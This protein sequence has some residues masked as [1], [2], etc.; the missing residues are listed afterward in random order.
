MRFATLA[1][2][3]DVGALARR[4]YRPT[5]A[6]GL[7]EAERVLLRANPQL[8]DPARRAP[9]V[10][11][12]VPDVTGAS[13]TN[14]AQSERQLLAS[15]LEA[16]RAQLGE[17]GKALGAGLASRRADVKA[18]LDQLGSAEI[19]RLLRE[20]PQLKDVL[21]GVSREAR[22]ETAE[23]DGLDTLH[24]KALG[25]LGQDLDELIRS[26]GGEP[27]GGQ[28][29]EGGEPP[30]PRPPGPG[31]PVPPT[32]RRPGPSRRREPR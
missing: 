27:G 29:T 16:A 17:V 19:Q 15:V 20:E 1:E 18:T 14:E 28:P 30:R 24:Q 6:E 2:N 25:E 7:R 11:V 32:G 31:R 23:L 22:A 3:E 4:L 9:G 21:A 8:A 12:M 13:A 10:V 26:V 5:T